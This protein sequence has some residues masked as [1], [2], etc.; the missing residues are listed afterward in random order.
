[1]S[2][3]IWPCPLANLKF[4]EFHLSYQDLDI[5]N[6]LTGKHGFD[7]SVHAPE[8]CCRDLLFVYCFDEASAI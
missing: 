6:P 3:I 1:M 4:V 5:A 2:V 8:L 7:F